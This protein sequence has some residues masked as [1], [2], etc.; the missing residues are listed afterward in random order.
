[1][2]RK[3]KLDP[4]TTKE[5][6]ARNTRDWCKGRKGVEHVWVWVDYRHFCQEG[7]LADQQRKVC[8]GCGKDGLERRPKFYSPAFLIRHYREKAKLTPGELAA[9][10]GARWEASRIAAIEAGLIDVR[11]NDLC[12]IATALGIGLRVSLGDADIEKHYVGR[13]AKFYRNGH[14]ERPKK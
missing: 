4:E 11:V 9:K 5:F 14:Y 6:N 8:D 12:D 10:M 1:L 7:E 13:E 3:N 2:K